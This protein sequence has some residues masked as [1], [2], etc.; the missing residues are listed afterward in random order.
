MRS[1]RQSHNQNGAN[2][3]YRPVKVPFI[4]YS[5]EILQAIYFYP[6]KNAI[7]SRNSILNLFI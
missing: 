2:K 7:D 3:R 1:P 5:A 4:A 6:F